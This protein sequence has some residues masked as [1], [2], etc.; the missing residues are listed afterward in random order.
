M[1]LRFGYAAAPFYCSVSELVIS[2]LSS[3]QLK[4][5]TL[6]KVYGASGGQNW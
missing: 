4:K 2:G 3:V 6:Q 1:K 5:G